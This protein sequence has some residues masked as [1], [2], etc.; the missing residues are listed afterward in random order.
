LDDLYDPELLRLTRGAILRIHRRLRTGSPNLSAHVA[1]WMQSLSGGAPSEHY[2]THQQAFPMLLLPWWLELSIRGSVARAFQREVVYS[3]VCGYYFVRM[4]DDAMDAAPPPPPE[5]LPALIVLHAEFQHAYQRYFPHGHPFWEALLSASYEAAETASIDA[6]V[7]DIDRTEFLRVSARKIAGAKVPIAAVCHHYRQPGLIEPWT[8]LVRA[9][10]RWHQ[11][12]NDIFD[13]RRDLERGTAT[14]FLSEA[15]RRGVP[16][17]SLTEWVL[18][19]GLG[20]GMGEL[21]AWMEDLLAAA[22]SL[23][24]PALSAYLGQRRLSLENDWQAL[25]AS[26]AS[27][28]RL[29]SL[30]G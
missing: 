4:I 12:R 20:W 14:Y 21:E 25:N 17:E 15:S 6:R 22:R 24:S 7:R 27:L 3:T 9:L 30:L 5:V 23:E 13:W 1:D 29:A 19:E 8:G 2:F 10:G 16:A 26:F 18:A 28:R 11:M